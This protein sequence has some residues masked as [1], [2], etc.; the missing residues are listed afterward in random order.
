MFRLT[1]HLMNTLSFGDVVFLL[2]VVAVCAFVG[3]RRITRSGGR[4]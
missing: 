1:E 3:W 2:G 4:S